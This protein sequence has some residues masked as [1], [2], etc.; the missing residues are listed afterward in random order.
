MQY[1]HSQCWQHAAMMAVLL[2]VHAY[3]TCYLEYFRGMAPQVPGSAATGPV[4]PIYPGQDFTYLLI[5]SGLFW[6]HALAVTSACVLVLVDTAHTTL[7]QQGA[8]YIHTPC[9]GMARL[10]CHGATQEGGLGVGTPVA[11]VQV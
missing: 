2:L 9:P 8:T 5:W 11:C 7:L 4:D 10:S 1:C 6:L 3:P